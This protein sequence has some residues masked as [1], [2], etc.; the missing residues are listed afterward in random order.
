M[1]WFI[2]FISILIIYKKYL[3]DTKKNNIRTKYNKFIKFKKNLNKTNLFIDFIE[4]Q[5]RIQMKY[6][7]LINSYKILFKEN[8]F[9]E[10]IENEEVIRLKFK[11][12]YNKFNESNKL[13]NSIDF[14]SQ[15]RLENKYKNRKTNW[16]IFEGK[17]KE[18]IKCISCNCYRYY[19]FHWILEGEYCD[20]CNNDNSKV[21]LKFKYPLKLR[22]LF[23]DN[24]L[25][26]K[27]DHELIHIHYYINIELLFKENPI[28][29]QDIEKPFDYYFT[30]LFYEAYK[31]L[32]HFHNYSNYEISKEYKINECYYIN[33]CINL[34]EQILE[35]KYY[36]DKSNKNKKEFKLKYFKGI[37]KYSIIDDIMECY[38]NNEMS[39]IIINQ[40]FY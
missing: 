11:R 15:K 16:W 32:H 12:I 8:V 6:N 29:L 13:V 3:I 25:Y 27:I 9:K 4:N 38:K 36:D 5:E 39:D 1:I 35:L 18:I 14:I 33:L 26:N 37:D 31:L 24:N 7:S 40:I 21:R 2:L 23:E 34:N 30:N 10:F 22:I 19:P 17:D 28:L 20:W